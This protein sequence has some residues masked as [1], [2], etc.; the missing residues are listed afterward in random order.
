M[1][2]AFPAVE[3]LGE[4]AGAQHNGSGVSFQGKAPETGLIERET[5][6]HKLVST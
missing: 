3:N 4:A 5:N 6:K 2:S 1:L